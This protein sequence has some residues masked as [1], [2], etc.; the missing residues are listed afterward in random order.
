VVLQYKTFISA[1]AKHVPK[2]QI[3]LTGKLDLRK[4]LKIFC[5]RPMQFLLH[6]PKPNIGDGAKKVMKW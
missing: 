2:Q 1:C 3:S 5:D 6:E 4:K